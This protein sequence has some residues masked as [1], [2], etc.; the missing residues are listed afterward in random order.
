MRTQQTGSVWVRNPRCPFHGI[1]APLSGSHVESPG[2]AGRWL[3]INYYLVFAMCGTYA[4]HIGSNPGGIDRKPA[5]QRACRACRSGDAP[6][7]NGWKSFQH[8]APQHG[9]RLAPP[10]SSP[11]GNPGLQI[12]RFSSPAGICRRL[13]GLVF[14][15][16]QRNPRC[17]KSTDKIES[18]ASA[19][20]T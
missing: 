14:P 1:S 8:C 11:H 3:L 2:S 5:G 12:A 17:C 7:R 10:Q 15:D 18:I 4:P 13:C 9:S 19:K 6:T 20:T 16:W